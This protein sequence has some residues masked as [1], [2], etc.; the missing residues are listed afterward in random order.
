MRT[1]KFVTKFLILQYTE[2][3]YLWN[4]TIRFL[5]RNCSYKDR[6]IRISLSQIRL[7]TIYNVKVML[8]KYSNK[9][10]CVKFLAN[11]NGC[12]C[13]FP[14]LDF[15]ILQSTNEPG[16]AKRTVLNN[17]T[18]WEALQCTPSYTTPWLHICVSSWKS[19]LSTTSSPNTPCY[20][21]NVKPVECLLNVNVQSYS[22]TAHGWYPIGRLPV[23]EHLHT[24]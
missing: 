11:C 16:Q 3:P 14:K 18:G 22:D 13:L 12:E 5:G 19:K 1:S 20:A 10:F 8:L 24:S 17:W 6:I 2:L 15:R 21:H 4:I 7:C 9:L 23:K